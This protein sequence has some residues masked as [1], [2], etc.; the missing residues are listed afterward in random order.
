MKM[1]IET[2]SRFCEE[3]S[4]PL[5]AELQLD[6]SEVTVEYQAP[7]EMQVAGIYETIQIVLDFPTWQIL[8][9]A[10]TGVVA[11]EIVKDAY[12]QTKEKILKL[13]RRNCEKHVPITYEN[14]GVQCLVKPEPLEGLAKGNLGA[15]SSIML[16]Y[17]GWSQTHEQGHAFD[18]NAFDKFFDH[19]D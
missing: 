8:I 13:F 2:D 16:T 3:V 11:K 17:S 14:A 7:A 19:Y 4:R 9:G 1:R 10:A 6:G 5:V 15:R 18:P 12:Q